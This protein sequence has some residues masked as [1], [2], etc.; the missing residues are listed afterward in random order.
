MGCLVQC[1]SKKGGMIVVRNV[2]NE[3]IPTRTVIGWRIC[4][5][6]QRLNDSTWKD[7]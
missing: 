5:N 3:L 2:K 1:V 4:I 7:H 6:Y